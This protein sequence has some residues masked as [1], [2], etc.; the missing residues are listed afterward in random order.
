MP[1]DMKIVRDSEGVSFAPAVSVSPNPQAIVHSENIASK[2]SKTNLD[3]I[4]HSLTEAIAFDQDGESEKTA[5]IEEILD[6]QGLG[7][8]ASPD[9]GEDEDESSDDSS[10]TLMLKAILGFQSRALSVMLPSDDIAVRT[11][12]AVDFAQI[13]AGPERDQM[14]ERVSAAERRV[15]RFYADYLFR[16]VKTYRA[17]TDL[18]LA[19]I[20]LFGTAVRKISLDRTNKKR[21]VLPERVKDGTLIISYGAEDFT[22]GRITHIC[23]VSTKDMI[24]RIRSGTY[25][26]IRLSDFDTPEK[27]DIQRAVDSVYAMS[28]ASYMSSETHRVYEVYGD[29]YFEDDPHPEKLPRPYVVTIHAATREVLSIQR[30]WDMSDPDE[31]AIEHFVVYTYHPGRT[32]V[33]G[34]G[35]GHILLQVTRSLRKAQRRGLE[36]A[37]LQNHPSGFKSSGMS[38]R[39]GATR[40][41]GGE[42]VDVDTP[43]GRIQDALMLHPFQ[44]PS[45][46][47]LAMADKME[48]N[49]RELGGIAT[50]D[51]SDMMKSGIAAGPAMAAFEDSTEFQTAVHL[52]MYAA[53]RREL[54]IIHDRMRIAI[55][56]ERFAFGVDQALEPGDLTLV[57]VLP[58]MKPGQASRQK[59]IMEAQAL[60]DIARQHPEKVRLSEAIENFVRALGSSTADELLIGPDDETAPQPADPVTEYASL[61]A[62]AGLKAGITQNHQAHIDAHAAQMRMLQVSQLPVEKGDLASAALSAHIAEHMG[63]QMIVE[64]AV[65]VGIS[66]QQL[67]PNMPPEIEAELA[68][69]IAQAIVAIEQER[70]PPEQGDDRVALEQIKAAAGERREQIKAA[71]KQTETQMKHAHAKEIEEIRRRHAEEIQ[72]MKDDAAMDREIEDNAAAIKIAKMKQSGKSAGAEAGADA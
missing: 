35:L 24:R 51:F 43:T 17:D 49:G 50:F 11:K 69:A 68:P 20:G 25:R 6:L 18:M 71:A 72:R 36:A 55:G 60:L 10:H 3:A 61:M 64:T 4:S 12:P 67:G 44:G 2:I 8:V 22:C 34:V 48:Q 57:D 47:L 56:S 9:S 45:A 29:F 19:R 70:R 33:E 66:P 38:V 30:N 59:I 23:D 46:G 65:R 42:F 32:P 5:V 31:E 15:S 39:Q 14:K 62:G 41:R 52:R 1:N 13:K 53:N 63:M 27:T 26:P 40:I 58:V 16:R 54:E 28:S 7:A 21:P 37:Y